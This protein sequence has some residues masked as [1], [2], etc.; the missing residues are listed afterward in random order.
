M[1]IRKYFLIASAVLSVLL[2]SA[3]VMGLQTGKNA[4]NFNLK[5]QFD[6]TWN[7]SGLKNK[8]V[9]V[10]AANRDSGESMGPWVDKL[11][12]RY[13]NKIQILGLLDLHDIPGIGRGIAK[14]RIKKETRDP[15]MLDF[16]GDTGK[17][18]EVSDNYPV[19]VCVDRKSQV[20][21]AQ[22]ALWNQNAWKV[23][24]NSIDAAL[25]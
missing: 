22:K 20:R 15:M 5:D 10:V 12:S 7:L 25:K 14:S 4:P 6:K 9:V 24:I 21:S 18:Y 13:G 19:V 23:T 1:M 16:K 17:A 11:K 2:L 8:V 3:A